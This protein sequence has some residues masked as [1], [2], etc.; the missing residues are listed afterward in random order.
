MILEINGKEYEPVFGLEFMEKTSKL[1][2]ITK[3]EQGITFNINKTYEMLLIHIFNLKD[4]LKTVDVITNSLCTQ[5]TK[6]SKEEIYEYLVT[7]EDLDGFYDDFFEELKNNR[8]TKIGFRKVL[9]KQV[10]QAK[11]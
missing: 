4:V 10:E 2:E 3:V 8:L 5:K 1:F 11:M 6:P 7:L 9:D